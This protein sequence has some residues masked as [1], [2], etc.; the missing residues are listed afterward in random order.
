MTKEIAR[1]LD[2]LSRLTWIPGTIRDYES[3][4]LIVH[5]IAYL[6]GLCKADFLRQFCFDTKASQFSSLLW[7]HRGARDERPLVNINQL[8]SKL[9]E[10][11]D[12]FRYSTVRA[13][14]GWTRSLFLPFL[15][16]CPICTYFGYHT[17]LFSLRFLARCPLHDVP[18]YDRCSCRNRFSD[19][20]EAQ[21]FTEAPG[22]CPCRRVRYVTPQQIRDPSLSRP[23]PVLDEL[24]QWLDVCDHR[25]FVDRT[26]LFDG[27]SNDDASLFRREAESWSHWLGLNVP[28]TIQQMP[29]RSEVDNTGGVIEEKFTCGIP[30]PKGLFS[31]AEESTKD[32]NAREL[33][34][35]RHDAY[36]L[37]LRIHARIKRHLVGHGRRWLGDL[38]AHSDADYIGR[39]IQ[40]DIEAR[41]AFAFMVWS[42]YISSEISL[43][44]WSS[45]LS[46]DE[47]GEVYFG[48]FGLRP[49]VASPTGF[50]Y[51]AEN[52][53][54]D[55]HVRAVLLW[56]T[57]EKSIAVVEDMCRTG[58]IRWGHG[59]LEGTVIWHWSA[60]R[61]LDGVL[62]LRVVRSSGSGVRPIPRPKKAHRQGAAR[63]AVGERQRLLSQQ[64]EGW[65]L[66]IDE[67]ECWFVGRGEPPDP[68][69]GPKAWKKH[70]LLGVKGHVKFMVYRAAGG[71]AFTARA[72]LPSIMAQAPSRAEA[73]SR[74][75]A[76]VRKH[77]QV[78]GPDLH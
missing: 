47:G 37:R 5:R 70:R 24:V 9:E 56:A 65:C 40:H 34:A 76:M 29:L 36:R 25:I 1:P 42:Q 74:L 66:G 57:W 55:A 72:F 59:V 60:A 2:E 17:I 18:L 27:R 46:S 30:L 12:R 8:A 14:Q 10:S 20:L 35:Y 54:I 73:I 31:P 16:L 62:T 19:A 15:R 21:L 77:E 49:F 6:N 23:F 78:L 38:A 51:S 26:A 52:R 4:F 7:N 11:E 28:A 53:W 3:L 64:C 75:R 44:R 32:M 63:K 41:R 48:L 45:A 69:S 68:D 58:D 61:S 43:R 50:T 13:F 67:N 71:E 39:C 33:K 22:W